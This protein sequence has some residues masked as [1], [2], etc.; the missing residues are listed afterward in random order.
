[1]NFIKTIL[2]LII[3]ASISFLCTV[4]FTY[5]VVF[6][7][8]GSSLQ[9]KYENIIHFSQDFSLAEQALIVEAIEKSSLQD[10]SVFSYIQFE[11][12][13]D[14][15]IQA[16]SSGSGVIWIQQS[17]LNLQDTNK[18]S[19]V[20]GHE[21][22]HLF[23]YFCLLDKDRVEIAKTRGYEI[24]NPTEDWFGSFDISYSHS[25]LVEWKSAPVEDFAE[26]FRQLYFTETEE[27][28]TNDGRKISN[29][30]NS[31]VEN[32][33][34]KCLESLKEDSEVRVAANSKRIIK[35]PELSQKTIIP[36]ITLPPYYGPLMF[37]RKD[38]SKGREEYVFTAISTKNRSIQLSVL[39]EP[40]G[41]VQYQTY[42]TQY[43]DAVINRNG[44]GYT[45]LNNQGTA[46]QYTLLQNGNHIL[47]SNDPDLNMYDLVSI[48]ETG[49]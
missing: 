23:D 48:M 4:V 13:D 49:N 15:A 7:K 37:L 8:N 31:T 42:F 26:V 19:R 1:M 44:K 41:Y 43:A 9:K 45:F 33:Y 29:E 27:I 32:A 5:T 40:D 35:E 10:V 11:K 22:G 14:A 39:Y 12:T 21:L 47:M 34:A 38:I 24:Q 46:K 20:I 3:I 17:L 18:L 2:S 28:L 25:N 6:S 30:T 16:V 36:L